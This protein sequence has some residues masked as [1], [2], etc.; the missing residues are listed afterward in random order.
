MNTSEIM[1]RSVVTVA[2]SASIEHATRLVLENRLS[3]RGARDVQSE[4]VEL[5]QSRG[6][7]RLPVLENGRMVGIVSRADLLRALLVRL[8]QATE[9]FSFGASSRARPN[10]RRCV[11]QQRILPASK[12]SS[13]M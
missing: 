1:T 12:A 4:V 8:P 6:I 2:P 11:W 9:S 7:K 3:R 10:A 13:T 5:M